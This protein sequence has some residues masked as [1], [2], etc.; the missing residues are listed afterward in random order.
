[1]VGPYDVALIGEV[2]SATPE[3]LARY[4]T[5]G[6]LDTAF[7][8][9]PV[10][11]DWEPA[12]LF[13]ELAAV[14]ERSPTSISW[15]IDNHDRSRSAS[16]FGQGDLGRARSF[17]VTALQF[18][19]GG[20]PFLYQGE[21]LA[22]EDGKIDAA[23]LADPVST[24]NDG[25]AGRD[26]CRTAM[27]WDMTN[28]NGFSEAEDVW[29]PAQMRS[30]D[31]TVEG[32]KADPDSWLR[33]YRRLLE[34]RSGLSALWEQPLQW[35]PAT[36]E[37]ARSLV[38]GDVFVASNLGDAAVQFELPDGAWSLVFATSAAASVSETLELPSAST[39]YLQLS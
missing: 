8:L 6:V 24:R 3:Q 22:L 39:A 7:H 27:P 10:W 18:A 13:D 5:P 15:V 9:E 35:M 29:L 16:R 32:Q 37:T 34:V 38:R 1:M 26:G 30:L 33:R 23:D 12:W 21:E 11:R 31:E 25:A 20:M 17:A 14:E 19:L 28:Q 2:G 36:T 4:V